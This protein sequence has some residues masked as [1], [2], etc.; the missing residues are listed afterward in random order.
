M[1]GSIINFFK[2]SAPQPQINQPTRLHPKNDLF[3]K[4]YRKS[5]NKLWIKK[6]HNYRP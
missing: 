1:L 4:E 3:N 2:R 6:I 5:Y